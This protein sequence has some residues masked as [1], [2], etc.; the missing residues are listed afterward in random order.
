MMVWMKGNRALEAELHFK[1][2][3]K[4]TVAVKNSFRTQ[5]ITFPA[6]TT[7]GVKMTFTKVMKGK[8]YNDLC[9]SEVLFQ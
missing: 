1:D 3:T 4:E 6:R 7:S 8:E 9:V 5:T 2:G